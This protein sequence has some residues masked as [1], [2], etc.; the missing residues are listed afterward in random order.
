MT[1]S[2]LLLTEIENDSITQLNYLYG[3]SVKKVKHD[4]KVRTKL[5]LL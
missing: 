2:V 5:K 4:I 3:D 1:N